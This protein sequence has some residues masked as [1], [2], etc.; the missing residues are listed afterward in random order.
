MD[1]KK[2]KRVI[3]KYKGLLCEPDQSTRKGISEEL[4]RA[5]E[6]FYPNDEYSR[7]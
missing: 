3:A 6:I 4:R 5:V 2:S 7:M 1:D